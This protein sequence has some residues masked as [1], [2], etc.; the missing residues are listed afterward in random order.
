[1][2]LVEEWGSSLLDDVAGSHP[3]HGAPGGQEL[4]EAK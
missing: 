3:S 1:M 4:A 2:V